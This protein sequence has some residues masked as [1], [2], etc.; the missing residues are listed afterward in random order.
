MKSRAC[1]SVSEPGMRECLKKKKKKAKKINQKK[2]D[3]KRK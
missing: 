1:A 3:L 2:G